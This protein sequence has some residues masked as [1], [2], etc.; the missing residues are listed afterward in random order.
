[1]KKYNITL[2]NGR[3]IRLIC[4]SPKEML[5]LVETETSKKKEGTFTDEGLIISELRYILWLM[6]IDGEK[7]EEKELG[8]N[9]LE[10][11][12]LLDIINLKQY[13][14]LI[15]MICFSQN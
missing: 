7:A 4:N 5:K 14:E 13:M 10:F 3:N 6:A 12:R 9:E 2:I 1:M 8:L 11:G 15:P